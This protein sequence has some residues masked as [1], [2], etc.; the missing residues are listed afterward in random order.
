MS[1][2][3]KVAIALLT[4]IS[5]QSILVPEIASAQSVAV[6]QGSATA[7]EYIKA[8][9]RGGGSGR[10]GN[11][12]NSV[13]G[14]NGGCIQDFRGGLSGEAAIMQAGCKGPAY[15]VIYGQWKYI[16]RTWGGNATN[17]IGYP[18]NDAYRNGSGWYQNFVGGSWVRTVIARS[19]ST[20]SEK[21]V[22]G[23]ILNY[24]LA[25]GGA[26]GRFR[27]PLTDSYPNNGGHRQDFEGGSIFWSASTGSITVPPPQPVLT[28]EQK[29][30]NWAIAEKNSP[31]PSWS[32]EFGRA[33]SGYCEGFVEVAYGKMNQF[34]SALN[35]YYWHL[36]S[37]RIRT[38]TSPP[39][40]AI[41]FYAG[42][43]YG[44]VG[45][46]IG[47]GQVI[48]TQGYG[49]QYLPVWQHSVTGLSNKYLG[50]A[51]APGDWAGR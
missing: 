5:I 17:V 1:S 27:Y 47:S 44:H 29:A 36:N 45:I 39:L 20:A 50:W 41:V 40:G 26:T 42:G 3:R 48:S 12:I 32:D 38:D 7:F 28:R 16:V 10:I 2:A 23:N 31:N 46:S 33:W 13:H 6:G 19:D 51:Y 14:W 30:A 24:W 37:G 8:F 21:S 34:T 25:N 22:R 9:Q 18:T 43:S 49:G 4:V 15:F 11:P 35:H